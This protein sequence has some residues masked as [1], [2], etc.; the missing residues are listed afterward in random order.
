MDEQQLISDI[1]QMEANGATEAD[2]A[3]YVAA[4]GSF[5]P[6]ADLPPAVGDEFATQQVEQQPIQG[7][8]RQGGRPAPR[9]TPGGAGNL[10]Q[11]IVQGAAMNFGDEAM[12]GIA[13]MY[14]KFVNALTGDNDD[15]NTQDISPITG[16]P[17]DDFGWDTA[18]NDV[19][20][21]LAAFEERNPVAAPIAQAGG[22]LLTGGYGGA[23]A[24]GSQALKNAPK[25]PAVL[26]IGATE[27]AIMGAG[28]GETAE[29]R[30]EGAIRG[31]GTGLATGYALNKIAKPISRAWA[32]PRAKQWREKLTPTHTIDTL[33]TEAD[34]LYKVAD[35]A[36][37]QVKPEAYKEWSEGILKHLDDR[38]VDG[39]VYPKLSKAIR[40]LKTNESPTYAQLDA[41]KKTLEGAKTSEK[42]ADRKFA[43]YIDKEL[44]NFIGGLNADQIVKGNLGDVQNSLSAA[45]DAWHRVEQAK[46]IER[47]V[48][49]AQRSKTGRQGEMDEAMT[50][51]MANIVNRGKSS[52]AMGEE[53][54]SK[55]DDII[56]GSGTK[57]FL[58]G[59][60]ETAPG[61]ATARGGI[62]I[63]TGV[64]TAAVTNDVKSGLAA[65]AITS[66]VPLVAGGSAQ[67]IVNSMTKNEIEILQ[68]AILNKNQLELNSVIDR[69][70]KKYAPEIGGITA[71]A[72]AASAD[73]L[74]KDEG[75]RTTLDQMMTPTEQR[76]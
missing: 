67:R 29:E 57:Q 75:N 16:K 10:G 45:R 53:N 18:T 3:E 64:L 51:Q 6:Q 60:A 14:A 63:S 70:I 25:V 11:Q 47:G 13:S 30:L 44:N 73:Q 27:S 49:R 9:S 32:S 62:P 42:L 61:A 5:T 66:A 37:L 74:L 68:N 52:R 59:M 36:G 34:R 65:A 22:S 12:G 15:L 55:L 39:R 76:P 72:S 20:R 1:I 54:V 48:S 69:V 23:K 26:G 4:V 21:D 33:Q 2:I 35:N 40:M 43:N 41:I 7:S 8:V 31:G 28:E 24:L 71:A 58:R 19:R 50:S 56:H 38:A 17:Y 46:L